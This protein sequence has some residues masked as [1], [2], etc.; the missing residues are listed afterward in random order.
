MSAVETPPPETPPEEPA[1]RTCPRC[2]SELTPRQDWCLACGADVG[3]R[4]ASAPGWRGPIA[5]VG[6]LLAI[7]VIALVLALVELAGNAETVAP[8][9]ADADAHAD[10]APA[11]R[12]RH[13]GV[14]H[15][16]AGHVGGHARHPAGDRRLAR[17]QGRVDGRAR[18]GLDAGGRHDARERARRPGRPGRAC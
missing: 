4:I 8:Q 15:D 7:A 9:A 12:D 14:D 13:A 1:P 2:G 3:T 6:G 17:G 18:V 10:R 11:H 5:V 16:P